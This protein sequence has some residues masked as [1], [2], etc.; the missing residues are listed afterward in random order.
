MGFPST[1]MRNSKRTFQVIFTLKDYLKISFF[2]NIITN[3]VSN[4]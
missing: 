3:V 4:Y 1:Y 2:S